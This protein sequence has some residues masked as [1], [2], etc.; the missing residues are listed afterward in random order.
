MSLSD[1]FKPSSTFVDLDKPE[2]KEKE[3][4]QLFQLNDFL[5]NASEQNRG[6]AFDSETATNFDKDNINKAKQGVKELMADV[7]AKAKTKAI[8]IKDQALKEGKNAGHE[9]GYQAGF[10]KGENKAK[11]EY[12]PLLETLNS[13]IRDLSEFRQM[14]Y[15]KVEKEMVEMVVGLTKKILGHEMNLREDNV[16]QMILLAANSVVNKENMV[17]RIHPSDKKHAEEFRPELQ[18]LYGEIKNITFEAQSRIERGGCEIVTNFGTVDAGIDQ[19]EEQIEKILNFT[20]TV[21][22]VNAAS[23]TLPEKTLGIGAE[24]VLKPDSDSTENKLE[25]EENGDG[26]IGTTSA[27]ELG[28]ALESKP[29]T[30]EA[31]KTETGTEKI[32]ESAPEDTENKLKS[33]TEENGEEPSSATSMREAEEALESEAQDSEAP[34]PEKKPEEIPKKLEDLSN[35]KEDD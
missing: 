11:E 15:P 14:M 3:E 4:A 12:G 31:P 27:D 29:P 25:I 6:F 20:P 34:T 17:I 26:P 5:E 1:Q 28:E 16:K 7:V 21:P 24:E 19:L 13:L 9:E 2:K 18:S 23:K 32:S 30:D 8:E 22:E 33:E 35:S 10:Q